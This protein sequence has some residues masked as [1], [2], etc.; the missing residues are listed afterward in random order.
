[1]A[2]AGVVV[3]PGDSLWRIAER[4]LQADDGASPTAA[5]TAVAWPSWWAANRPA[6]GDD[7][8]LLRP[9]TVL[10]PPAH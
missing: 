9:G 10:H 8:D 1:V 6:I 3:E 5:R 7:P 4:Q 2:G